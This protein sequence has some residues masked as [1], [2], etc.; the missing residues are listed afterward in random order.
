ME[1]TSNSFSRSKIRIERSF[2]AVVFIPC[3]F[4]VC[5]VFFFAG[6]DIYLTLTT[7]L[8][9][10]T[11]YFCF[12]NVHK[13]IFFIIFL[14][15]FYIFLVSGEV[16]ECFLNKT[17]YLNLNMPYEATRHSHICLLISMAFLSLGFFVMKSKKAN[18][19][20]PVNIMDNNIKA[21]QR[22]SLMF[23]YTTYWIMLFNSINKLVFVV[24]NGYV[25]YYSSYQPLLPSIVLQLGDFCPMAFCGFLATFPDKKEIKKPII[26]YAV[27][28]LTILFMGQRGGIIYIGC[29]LFGLLL[30]RN[31][32]YSYSKTWVKKPI[33][34][35]GVISIPFLLVG[36]QLI[37]FLR[38]GY[39]V[40]YNSFGETL[41][42]FFINIGSS[43]VVIK[44]GYVYRD[45]IQSFRFFSMGD[46][47]NYFK[48]GSTFTWLTGINAPS[49]HSE[50]F[51]LEGHSFDAFISYMF[52]KTEFLRGE[53]AGSS[54][55][56]ELFADFGYLG[57]GLGSM[58]YG[59]LFKKFS[60]LDKSN[61]ILTTIKLYM[62][63]NIIKTPRGS[64][65]SPFGVVVNLF[66]IAFIFIC[67]SYASKYPKVN[68]TVP[69]L[70]KN[71]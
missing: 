27:N 35:I 15:S 8:F 46:I 21:Y 28:L 60:S 54:F 43:S 39:D 24:K 4:I 66:F 38:N 62:I 23:F 29:F 71:D 19:I 34:V 42:D 47:L 48:Y 2:S 55:V 63:M 64:F 51:A 20:Q 3:L 70:I 12:A 31:K 13:N 32:Y 68:H 52:M 36:L 14:F 11:L 40:I 65:A 49:I 45:Q 69:R 58:I 67:H 59:I 18:D 37:T 9:L 44:Y 30:Y 50:T 25:A 22:V 10:I 16:A 17:Y 61:W 1:N 53:G 7:A 33:I 5:L 56:A 41:G 26:L 57:V 6:V